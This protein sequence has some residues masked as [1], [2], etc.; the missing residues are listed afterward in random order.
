MY[1]KENSNVELLL[2]ITGDVTPNFQDAAVIGTAIFYYLLYLCTLAGN[3]S[4]ERE[5]FLRYCFDDL[6]KQNESMHGT[7]LFD[8]DKNTNVML[9]VKNVNYMKE[10]LT[11][12]LDLF[13]AQDN[14]FCEKSESR[15]LPIPS[16]FEGSAQMALTLLYDIGVS[17][18]ACDDVTVEE[19]K[20]HATFMDSLNIYMAD[21]SRIFKL[22]HA[23][24]P[25]DQDSS[26]KDK[27]PVAVDD[28]K[29]LEYLLCDL[30]DLVGLSEV[31]LDVL[32]I[33]ALTQIRKIRKK[34]RLQ[35]P[36]ISRHLVFTGNPG[37]GKTS[38]GVFISTIYKCLGFVSEGYLV[39]PDWSEI[40]CEDIGKT[41]LSVQN[42]IDDASG[43]ILYL[44]VVYFLTAGTEENGHGNKILEMLLKAMEENRDNFIVIV[45][46][47]ADEVEK[48]LESYPEFRSK[49]SMAINFPDYNADELIEIF[50]MF[51]HQDRIKITPEASDCVAMALKKYHAAKDENYANA[52]DVSRFFEKAVENQKNRIAQINMPTDDDLHMLVKSDVENITL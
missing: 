41:V 37:T 28:W 20:C 45:S 4:S 52:R 23:S 1:K 19:A 10:L 16:S 18:L 24:E 17:L 48:F 21:K 32:A 36:S 5:S 50:N 8:Y 46:G 39:K 29:M 40:V 43:G 38:I 9:H 3:I 47:R 44:D 13:I 26:G 12:Y 35:P 6:R 34:R 11:L 14:D 15:E 31:K 27:P 22:E 49:F 2:K 51:C 42:V 25:Q 30:H 7:D 33:L